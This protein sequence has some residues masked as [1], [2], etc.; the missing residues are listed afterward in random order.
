[1]TRNAERQE[2]R[3][4]GQK[5]ALLQSRKFSRFRGSRY[6]LYIMYT[7]CF[8][9]SNHPSRMHVYTRNIIMDK[10]PSFPCQCLF[11]LNA[12]YHWLMFVEVDESC[13]LSWPN[14][15]QTARERFKSCELSNVGHLVRNKLQVV[16]LEVAIRLTPGESTHPIT[17]V[18]YPPKVMIPA[19]PGT[20]AIC[21]LGL[22]NPGQPFMV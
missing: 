14:I 5:G 7:L 18:F 10:D 19:K 12:S 11:A 22:I 17:G 6:I 13:W 8:C 4:N 21:K 16:L 2:R 3:R 1:M 15:G 20:P 9:V